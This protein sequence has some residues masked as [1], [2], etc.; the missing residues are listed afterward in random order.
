MDKGFKHE[1]I[2]KAVEEFMT[3]I[4]IIADYEY[5]VGGFVVT[6]IGVDENG[7]AYAISSH[8]ASNPEFWET[9]YSQLYPTDEEW[10]GIVEIINDML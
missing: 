5:E 8:D 7:Y 9:K 1:I 6:H 3:D 4:F 2:D 10:A